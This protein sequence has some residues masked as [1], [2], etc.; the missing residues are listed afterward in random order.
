[1]MKGDRGLI[2]G[3]VEGLLHGTVG[4]RR[5]SLVLCIETAEAVLVT[6]TS[7]T[8]GADP[9]TGWCGRRQP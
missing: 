2:V 5:A 6:S 8:A 7:R 4:G 9:D 3:Y 1:M